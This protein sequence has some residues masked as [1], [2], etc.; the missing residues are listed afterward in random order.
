ML[1]ARFGLLTAS[2]LWLGCAADKPVEAADRPGP[3]LAGAE[4]VERHGAKAR[5]EPV[6]RGVQVTSLFR[7]PHFTFA[8]EGRVA[9]GLPRSLKRSSTNVWKLYLAASQSDGEQ[10][11]SNY[12]DT[13]PQ[14]QAS[15]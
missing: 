6:D 15:N 7:S 4:R 14:P 12:L 5:P 10:Q 13:P 3:A 9:G 1:L 2:P 11:G 8:D